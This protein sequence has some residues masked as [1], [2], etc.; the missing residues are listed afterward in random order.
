MPHADDLPFT[1]ELWAEDELS[2]AGELARAAS[3]SI[4]RAAF[5]TAAVSYPNRMI[6]LRGPGA[7]EIHA[8]SARQCLPS[9]EVA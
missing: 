3:L 5:D 6:T 7:N 1:V 8:P 9:V 2:I 4:A